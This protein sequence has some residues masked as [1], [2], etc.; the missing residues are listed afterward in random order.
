[1]KLLF[2]VV[3]FVLTGCDPGG[4]EATCRVSLEGALVCHFTNTAQSP[5]EGCTKPV[6]V[7]PVRRL[8]LPEVCS[9]V[10]QGATGGEVTS[11]AQSQS[12][13]IIA[14]CPNIAACKTEVS[15]TMNV[16]PQTNSWVV[17]VLVCIAALLAGDYFR[18]RRATT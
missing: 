3:L 7:G 6:L 4:L 10:M 5:V 13:D 17:W 8:S 2:V 9:G 14:T 1:M 18:R 12:A 11:S 15:V 16:Q